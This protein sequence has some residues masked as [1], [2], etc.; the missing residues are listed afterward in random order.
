MNVIFETDEIKNQMLHSD[1]N[2]FNT[3][4]VVDLKIQ[5]IKGIPRVYRILKLH[6]YFE[7]DDNK[8]QSNEE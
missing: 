8:I 3:A 2:P 5:N 4:F 6:E 1:I 7:I